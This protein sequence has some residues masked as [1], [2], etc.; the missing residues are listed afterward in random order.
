[1][2]NQLF[3]DLENLSEAA[4]RDSDSVRLPSLGSVP[5]QRFQ[6]SSGQ[7][8]VGTAR[9]RAFRSIGAFFEKH[10]LRRAAW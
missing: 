6:P 8:R 5:R 9:R 1:V 2:V 10:T 4:A 7:S 3:H